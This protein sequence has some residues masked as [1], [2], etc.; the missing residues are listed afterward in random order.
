MNFPSMSDIQEATG[1]NGRMAFVVNGTKCLLGCLACD[2]TFEQTSEGH[3]ALRS[4]EF[5]HGAASTFDLS[6]L[7]G[8]KL[9]MVVVDAVSNNRGYFQT[10]SLDVWG[11]DDEVGVVY[12]IL[13]KHL[14]SDQSYERV[15]WK[16]KL[17]QPV[18]GQKATPHVLGFLS[19]GSR[20]EAEK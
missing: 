12:G 5:E 19:D 8:K 20:V 10:K 1:A 3:K 18:N 13:S 7:N 4:H 6:L 9:R 2:A 16:W 17:T 11:V 15:G 14:S